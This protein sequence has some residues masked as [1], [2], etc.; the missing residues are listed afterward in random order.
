M[1]LDQR[2]R[3]RG[4][5]VECGIADPGPEQAA[6]E[7]RPACSSCS[8]SVLKSPNANGV[9]AAAAGRSLSAQSAARSAERRR[10][11]R[12]SIS[13]SAAKAAT[14][15]LRRATARASACRVQLAR[16][17][18]PPWK[19]K[20]DAQR[21]RDD[22]QD[23]RD[24][25]RAVEVALLERIQE[26]ELVQRVVLRHD[27]RGSPAKARAAR[28]KAAF[29]RRTKE[30]PCRRSISAAAGSGCDHAVRTGPAPSMRAASISRG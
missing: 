15:P 24:R 17:N 20:N 10:T 28:R 4:E 13:T 7:S 27:A 3:Q 18:R 2:D 5:A 14:E 25:R 22:Q 29:R 19:T 30:R 12:R 23:Q 21:Q 1:L 6:L 11:A 26:R 8:A 9:R 16:S